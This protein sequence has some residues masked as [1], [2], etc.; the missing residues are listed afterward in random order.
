MI[1]RQ[2]DTCALVCDDCGEEIEFDTFQE[3][4]DYKKENGWKSVKDCYGNWQDICPDCVDHCIN[5]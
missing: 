2:R 5:N 3:C 1:E 4:V